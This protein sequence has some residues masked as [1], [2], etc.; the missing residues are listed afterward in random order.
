M[1]LLDRTDLKG[2]ILPRGTLIIPE[3]IYR[4]FIPDYF[5][6]GC[7]VLSSQESSA[8]NAF[9]ICFKPTHPAPSGTFGVDLLRKVIKNSEY[10]QPI[11]GNF[12]KFSL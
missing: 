5:L 10:L 8:V 9:E 3:D 1:I 7:E 12:Y 6:R 4:C 11:P 2:S